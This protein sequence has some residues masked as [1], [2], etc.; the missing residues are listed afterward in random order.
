VLNSMVFNLHDIAFPHL[1]NLFIAVIIYTYEEKAASYLV[2]ALEVLANPLKL[3]P[4]DGKLVFLA[5]SKETAC[6]YSEACL[7]SIKCSFLRGEL[8]FLPCYTLME[9][10][11]GVSF[12]LL[13]SLNMDWS[14]EPSTP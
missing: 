4:R 5:G 10:A 6:S 11:D 13:S 3:S 12:T 14:T 2:P 8:L 9:H 7:S 1:H